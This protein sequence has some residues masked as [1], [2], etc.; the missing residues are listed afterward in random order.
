MISPPIPIKTPAGDASV[1]VQI[2]EDDAD[3]TKMVCWVYYLLKVSATGLGPKAWLAAVRGAI[4]TMEQWARDA[5]C[6]EMRIRGRD[7]SRILPDY[8]FI[9]GVPNGLKKRLN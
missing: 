5:G 4:E 1:F 8:D 9:D 2:V 6:A 3:P 7:W